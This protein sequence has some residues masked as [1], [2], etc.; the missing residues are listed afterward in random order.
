[1]GGAALIYI[2]WC[3][4]LYE[5]PRWLLCGGALMLVTNLPLLV[6]GLRLKVEVEMTLYLFGKDVAE[7]F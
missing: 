6:L 3:K 2:S 4:T 1:M 7:N 5:G